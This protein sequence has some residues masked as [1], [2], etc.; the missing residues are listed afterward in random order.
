MFRAKTLI[1]VVL[2]FFSILFSV[3]VKAEKN[4]EKIKIVAS[5]SPI[6]SVFAAVAG[7]RADVSSICINN[8]C[9]AHY[10]AKPSHLQMVRMADLVVYIDDAFEVFMQKPLQGTRAQ[11]LKLSSSPD[12]VTTINAQTDLGQANWPQNNWHLWLSIHN[13]KVMLHKALLVLSEIDPQNVEIYDHNYKIAEKSVENLKDQMQKNLSK[14]AKPILLD[15]SLEY[16]FANFKGHDEVFRLYNSANKTSFSKL[17][18]V[19]DYIRKTG[20]KC[21]FASSHQ[22]ISRFKEFFAQDVR[23]VVLES[24]SWD[25]EKQ[26]TSL[27]QTKLQYMIDLVSTCL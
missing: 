1:L 17:K 4:N 3:N 21:A 11:V 7:G 16:F 19:K 20:I 18:E 12:L 15:D 9:P 2:I 8:Q 22:D 13:L 6:A 26:Y 5:I 10:L 24:E 25:F 27:L 23:I 14:L